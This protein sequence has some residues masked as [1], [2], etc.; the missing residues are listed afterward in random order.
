MK[1]GRYIQFFFRYLNIQYL[2]S[3][4]HHIPLCTAIGIL[5]S[6]LHNH[7][8]RFSIVRSLLESLYIQPRWSVSGCREGRH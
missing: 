2:V 7:H 5:Q 6:P 3:Y 8:P 4:I 1:V